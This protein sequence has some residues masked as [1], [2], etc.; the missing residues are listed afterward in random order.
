MIM[1][2]NIPADKDLTMD[3]IIKQEGYYDI[4]GLW[5]NITMI[6]GKLY[7][8]RVETFVIDQENRVYMQLLDNGG[9]RIPGGSFERETKHSEQAIAEV[10]EEAKIVCKN[11]QYS[12]VHY[13]KEFKKKYQQEKGKIFWDGTYNEVYVAEY[14]KRY[15]GIINP[16]NRDDEMYRYGNWYQYGEIK[17]RLSDPHKKV[18]GMILDSNPK[19]CEEK[20]SSLESALESSMIGIKEDQ[21]KKRSALMINTNNTIIGESYNLIDDIKQKISELG[22]DPQIPLTSRNIQKINEL[23]KEKNESKI[24]ELN[25]NYIFTKEDNVYNFDK[26]DSGKSNILLV[27]GLSG[28]G[29]TTLAFSLAKEY[30]ATVIQLDHLQCYSRFIDNNKNTET[31]KIISKFLKSHK[32]LRDLDFS[33]L[34]LETFKPVFDEFFPWLLKELEKDKKNRYI[35]EGI[36]ILLFTKYSDIKKY[37]LICINTPMY[38]SIIRHWIRDQFTLGELVKYGI[39]DIQLFKNWEDT[40]QQF[41]DSMEEGYYR[42]L[43]KKIDPKNASWDEELTY[44]TVD[45]AIKGQNLTSG[46]YYIYDMDPETYEKTYV[47]PITIDEGY[48]EERHTNSNNKHFYFYHLVPKGSDISKGLLSP[49][50]MY[51]NG[52]DVSNALDKYRDRLVDGWDIYPYKKPYELTD[53]EIL[54]GLNKFRGNGGSDTIYFFRYPP[55]EDLGINM[56]NILKKKDI[57]RID[58]NDKDTQKYV[59]EINW[60]YENS[61]TRNKSLN[62][63]YYENVSKDEYFSNYDDNNYPLFAS[64]NHIGVITKYGYIPKKCIEKV[65]Y[66]SVIESYIEESKKSNYKLKKITTS[67]EVGMF[68]K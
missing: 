66:D 38:K 5:N 61:H 59:R 51:D 56:K 68:Y 7:R 10:L 50:Y 13:L 46:T 12:G 53:E 2:W 35:V 67:N 28:S 11:I 16:K 54:S 15:N 21:D 47:G 3:E 6:D 24:M 36:H 57:Y 22:L 60:G 33:D 39:K 52:I 65:S 25:E 19:K 42:L 64:I 62:K 17:D 8:G 20:L 44:D 1:N 23:E 27:T 34:R 30:D 49:Q 37:P 58:L 40:Y 29:K 31:I 18:L 45:D 41:Y 63:K 4:D 48:V 26:W 43:D 32:D 9:Y 55:Y 14:E